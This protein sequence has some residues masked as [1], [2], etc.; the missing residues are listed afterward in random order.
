LL[1]IGKS[2]LLLGSN[3]G[4]RLG[5]LH[6]AIHHIEEMAGEI[7]K[8]SKILET[9]PWGNT[10]QGNFVNQAV[11]IETKLGP[12]NLLE[13][14]LGIEKLIGRERV[15]KWGPRII[16]I[17]ILYYDALHIE[18]KDLKIPHPYLAERKF[19][20]IPLNEISA[21]WMH[22]VLHKT[23]AQLLADCKDES[24]VVVYNGINE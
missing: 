24:T 6:Q 4:D 13:T 14:L 16:D 2:A 22:P 5:Y 12:E 8:K 17:D 1:R 15:E 19:T 21:D 7:I 20:L 10:N 18:E 9:A 11:L 3:E 23:V